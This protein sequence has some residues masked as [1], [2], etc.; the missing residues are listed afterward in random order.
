[1]INLSFKQKESLKLNETKILN[2]YFKVENAVIDNY[3]IFDNIYESHVFMI[4]SRYC[5]N[6][7]VAFPSYATL[8]KK[9]YCSRRT[10]IKAIKSL[11][12]KKLINKV[13]RRKIEL[14]ENDTNLYTVN[15][16]I[17]NSEPLKNGASNEGSA[18]GALGGAGD[19]PNKE[20]DI[21]KKIL[22][23]HDYDYL[24]KF[25]KFFKINLPGINFT[26]TNQEAIKKLLKNLSEKNVEKYLIELYR[27]ISNNVKVKNRAAVFSYKL[28]NRERQVMSKP[29]NSNIEKSNITPLPNKNN[30]EIHNNNNKKQTNSLIQIVEITKEEYEKMYELFLK[31]AGT[32]KIEAS[33]NNTMRAIFDML[34][35]NK[36]KIAG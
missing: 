32:N 9:C 16:I 17:E 23:N 35:K 29:I 21:N 2:S 5:N 8:A 18:Y 19:A 26:K 30:Q 11:E 25:D 15:N 36:Y 33:K 10:I 1:M 4:F 24:N 22:N 27:Q 14:L 13:I 3:E 6:N 20:K 31:G 12:E 34:N 28:K 7:N